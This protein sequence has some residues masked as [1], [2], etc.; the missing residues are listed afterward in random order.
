MKCLEAFHPS[1]TLPPYCIH[2]TPQRIQPKE[3]NQEKTLFRLPRSKKHH[4]LDIDIYTYAT[5]QAPPPKG[6]PPAPRIVK[7]G[8]PGRNHAF[9]FWVAL[10]RFLVGVGRSWSGH[11]R[12]VRNR[13]ECRRV[14]DPLPISNS[15]RNRGCRDCVSNDWT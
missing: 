8:C 10:G 9:F 15:V 12:A 5:A 14:C 1:P 11:G 6:V 2:H 4:A 3:R 7:M 13:S